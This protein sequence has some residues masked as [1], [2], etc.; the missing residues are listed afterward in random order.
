[1]FR[2]IRVAKQTTGSE[3]G[4]CCISMM[5]SWFGYIKPIS[6]FRSIFDVGRDGMSIDSI[7]DVFEKIGLHTKVLKIDNI[8]ELKKFNKEP[9]ILY[10]KNH[11]VILKNVGNKKAKIYDPAQG[12]INIDISELN[13]KFQGIILVTTP[14]ETFVKCD[15]KINDFKYIIQIIKKLKFSIFSII[16][17]TMLTYLITIYIPKY[18]EYIINRI[19]N[20]EKI[21]YLPLV[22]QLVFIIIVF[23]VASVFLNKKLINLQ[24]RIYKIMKLESIRKLFNISFSFFDNRTNANILYRLSLQN[25]VQ[26]MI[27]VYL[28]NIIINFASIVL[29]LVYFLVFDIGILFYL[30]VLMA[31]IGVFVVT[32][33]NFILRKQESHLAEL[34]NVT[35]I[36]T[37]IVTNMFQI[38]CMNLDEYYTNQYE[39]GINDSLSKFYTFQTLQTSFFLVINSISR[40]LPTIFL[41]ILT[42]NYLSEE[43]TIGSL[44]AIYTFVGM[45]INYSVQFFTS[46]SQMYLM[47]SSLSYINDIFEEPEILENRNVS[48]NVF[49]NYTVNNLIFSYN[50]NQKNTLDNINIKFEKGKKYALIGL[51]GSGKT[52]LVKILAGL[53]NDYSGELRINNLEYRTI[54]KKTIKEFISIVPQ[55]PVIF[56]KSLRHNITMGDNT[57][58]DSEVLN[59]LETVAFTSELNNFPMGLDTFISSNDNLSGGQIQRIMIARALIRNPQFLILDEATSA[60]DVLT[61]RKIYSNIEKSDITLLIITHRLSS[62]ENV[63]QIFIMGNGKIIEE[64]SH[65]KLLDKNGMYTKMLKSMEK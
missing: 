3:C 4:L 49:E 5:A 51:S 54:E 59:A 11:F 26:N 23:I 30:A 6:F 50:D 42:L 19:T 9:I 57:I 29:I 1:M 41:I 20:H 61:E 53:Y 56:N 14:N 62:I 21:L 28:P 31:M 34:A 65:K 17:F 22:A 38:K 12:I 48:L 39:K 55:I 64:G 35:N 43:K 24:Q 33:N 47:K 18:I 8:N 40:F 16:F 32:T 58:S 45:F 46:C 2:R 7:V 25:Q 37:E 10:L 60:V 36:E 63:D 52:T 13:D 44:V 27:S 15:D